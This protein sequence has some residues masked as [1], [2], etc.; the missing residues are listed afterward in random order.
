MAFSFFV[1]FGGALI[2]GES[3]VIKIDLTILLVHPVFFVFFVF[4]Q[5]IVLS[6]YAFGE[7]GAFPQNMFVAYKQHVLI[8]PACS[9]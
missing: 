5:H 1:Y 6:A 7:L 9:L 2:V 3:M 8:W 4:S